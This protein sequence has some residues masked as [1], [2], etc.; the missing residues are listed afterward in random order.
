MYL[1]FDKNGALKE[2]IN[3]S[4]IRKGNNNA[5][6]VYVYLEDN[7]PLD[8]MT[9]IVKMPNG[10]LT[11]EIYFSD[12]DIVEEAIP[13]NPKADYKYFKDFVKYKFYV[14]NLAFA[15]NQSGLYLMTIRAFIDDSI[16]AKGEIT[17]NA[18]PN[19]INVD[20]GITQSQYDYLV[21]IVKTGIYFIPEVSEEGVLS[22]TNTGDLPNPDPVNVK[23]PRGI[24]VE[25]AVQT[26]TTDEDDGINIVE[27]VLDNGQ[28]AGSI[29][30]KNGSKGEQGEPAINAVWFEIDE[31]T[32]NLIM[33]YANANDPNFY[34]VSDDENSD[35]YY[36]TLGVS[37]DLVGHIIFIYD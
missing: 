1:Y 5:N 6:K 19:I 20:N 10:K 32:G 31:D 12:E 17:F 21:K 24:S 34:L 2:I 33:Y 22:W 28:V 18:E 29:E 3:D 7:P 30:V 35:S 9:A 13:Y 23:G 16:F 37:S 8:F 27:F 4:S 36:E 26:Q 11:N 14:L 25:R 15:L